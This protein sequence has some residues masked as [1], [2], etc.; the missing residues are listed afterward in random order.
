VLISVIR[1]SSLSHEYDPLTYT[2][3][4]ENSVDILAAVRLSRIVGQ[5]YYILTLGKFLV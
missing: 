4:H 3:L 2:K 5:T 1:G